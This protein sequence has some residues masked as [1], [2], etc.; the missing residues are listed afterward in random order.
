MAG[1]LLCSAPSL[2]AAQASA[3]DLPFTH[4]KIADGAA[5]S[6]VC[7]ACHGPNGNSTN[8]EWP[9]LA[10]QSAVYIA[11]QLR[12]FRTGVRDNPVMQPQ[13]AALSDKDIDDLAVYFEAQ[14]PSGLEA[15]PTYWQ[16]GAALYR[17]G[18]R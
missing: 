4:G 9:R 17:R 15:D 7:S 10:G 16:A 1:T 3:A 5:R 18:D 2:S 14:M 6:V 13:A 8:P 11:E 12:L